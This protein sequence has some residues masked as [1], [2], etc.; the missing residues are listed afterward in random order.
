MTMPEPSQPF[1]PPARRLTPEPSGPELTEQTQI[2]ADISHYRQLKRQ[3][4]SADVKRTAGRSGGKD[5][6]DFVAFARIWAPYG[7]APEDEIFI[8]FGMTRN[9]FD[10]MLVQARV[11]APTT[12][13]C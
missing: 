1:R 3:K 4:T 12:P 11:N 2:E 8:R 7:G 10:E 5:V 13:E 6:D 9:R